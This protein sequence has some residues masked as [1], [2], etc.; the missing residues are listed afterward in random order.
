ML[1]PSTPSNLRHWHRHPRSRSLFATWIYAALS[2]SLT[3]ASPAALWADASF[4][5]DVQSVLS[6]AGCNAGTCHG[7][8]NGKGG[9]KLSLRGQDDMA[10]F[11]QLTQAA[12]GRRINLGAPAQSL[13]LKKALGEIPHKGGVRF[14]QQSSEY[15]DLVSWIEAGAPAPTASRPLKQL[16]VEP[17]QLVVFAPQAS[18]QIRVRACFADGNPV[19]VTDRACYE[20]SNLKASVDA[21]G[22][23]T[24]EQFGETTL[25]V[26]YLHLQV[27]VRLA[28]REAQPDFVWEAPD[29]HGFV[30]EHVFRKLQSLRIHPSALCSDST[31][32]R[33]LYLDVIGRLPNVEETRAFLADTDPA[34]RRDLIDRLLNR[35]EFADYWALKYADILRVEEKVLD[36]QGVEIFHGWIREQ[37]HQGVPL[38]EWIRQL[39]TGTGST[40]EQ[41]AANFYRA[42]RDP[43]TR[44]ET[45]ARLFLGTR[46]QCAKC[47]NHPYDR[48][49]QEEYY[50]WANLFSQLDY[51]L[52]E[53]K[54]KDRLDKNEFAGEQIVKVA[55]QPEVRNPTTGREVPPKFLGGRQ[56][57]QDERK[58]RLNATARWLTSS[59]NEKFVQSQ[60]NFV[61]YHVMGRGL[62]DPVD[63]FRSTNPASNPALLQALSV[64][65]A[66]SGFDLRNLIR[67]ILVSRTYQTSSTPRPSNRTD[68]TNYS[69]AYVRRHTAEVLLDMQSDVLELP[70]AFAGFAP[71]IRA[72]QIPGV[73]KVR[74]RDKRPQAGDR[75]LRTFGKPQ[76][77]LACDCERSNETHLKQVLG[78]VGAELDDRLKQS[79]RL[80]RLAQSPESDRKILQELYLS[81]LS[82][83]PTEAELQKSLDVIA[84]VGRE[85]AL[86]D[87]AWAILNAKE[88]LFRR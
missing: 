2:W 30:D 48:W 84:Q 62:V 59:Q 26:R 23:V 54:R 64:A 57:R 77:I 47:H 72:V 63:D 3:L 75:F 29:Q 80:K 53:N 21:G 66:D 76:R 32:L 24:R 5:V 78:L 60:V 42:N 18:V 82:R 85:A 12:R 22:L 7:N 69:R 4:S 13:L 83:H 88:F 79:P 33:R 36:P 58:Q 19:D 35:P 52:G 38:D 40:F 70:A 31:F 28:F 10:D 43:A 27:P 20:L 55:E 56:L 74:R 86:Q 87:I 37:I 65:F 73:E 44:G 16:V 6:K 15:Q 39:V 67:T 68:D 61:W 49:T 25:I 81:A 1:G 14:H 41:P 71:G 46:L 8:L 17:Q 9:F 50:Q 34:K 45:T 51:D 11:T